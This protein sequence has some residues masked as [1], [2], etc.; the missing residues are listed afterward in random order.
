MDVVVAG[1]HGLLGTT[2]VDRLRAR[3]DRVRRLVRRE[4][5]APDELGWDPGTGVLDPRHLDGAD[6]VVNLGGAGVGTRYWSTGYKRTVLESRTVPTSLIARTLARAA[7]PPPTWLQASAVGWYGDRGDTPL[8]E[9]AAP[10]DGFLAGVVTRWEA[11]TRPAQDAGT[12]V[13]HLRTG[14]VL[15]PDPGRLSNL[16][17]LLR[18]QLPEGGT[19]AALLPILRTGLG[20][21]L[22][23]GTQYWPWITLPDETG[24]MLHLL[25]PAGDAVRGPVN[26]TAPVP[27][28]NRDVM[29]ALA[30]VVHRPALVRVPTP[31]LRVALGEFSQTLTDSQRVLPAALEASGHTFEHPTLDDAARWLSAA[32]DAAAVS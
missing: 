16:L 28:R 19:L 7:D 26:L 9:S 5:R 21:P 20:G 2:L 18:L 22:G 10:G 32:R 15:A 13:V 8:T 11:A 1:S 29:A 12:R 25:G 23:P 31:A 27:A 4:P 24:A 14:I 6:A 17:P 30:R 3:G